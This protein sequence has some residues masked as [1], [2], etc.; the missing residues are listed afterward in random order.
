[1]RYTVSPAAASFASAASASAADTITTM[2][3][4]QLNTRYISSWFTPPANCSQ[5]NICG[6]AQVSPSMR[7][8]SSSRRM[9]GTFSVMPPPVM[10]AMPLTTPGIARMSSSMGLT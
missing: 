10:W 9:R 6:S 3:M 4:P 8:V 2:P 7:A 1:M 5:R